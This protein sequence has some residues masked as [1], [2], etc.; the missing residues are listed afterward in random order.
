MKTF[1]IKLDLVETA[2]SL[3]FERNEPVLLPRSEHRCI[4]KVT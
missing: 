4:D 1:S 2:F 3:S